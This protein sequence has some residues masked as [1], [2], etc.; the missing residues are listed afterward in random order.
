MEFFV[1]LTRR[2]AIVCA[3]PLVLALTACG[4]AGEASPSP[5]ADGSAETSGDA[6]AAY[7]VT[8][9]NCG[10]EVTVTE[11]PMRIVTIKSTST[12][13]VLA[14]GL[15]DRLVGT[16]FS[17]GP[18]PEDLAGAGA[19][20]PVLAERAPSEEVVLETEPDLVFAGWESNFS[21][22]G[23]GERT[24]LQELGIATYVSPAAC[25]G[26][27]YQP[28]P[29]TFDHIFGSIEE[30]GA[31]LGAPDA[32]T[33]LIE[34]Q[35]AELAEVDA[36]DAGLSALWYSS[37]SDTP[38]VGAGIGAPQLLMETVGLENIMADTAETWAS[39]SWEAVAEQNPDV[40]VLVDSAWNTAEH[41][42]E[43]LE[44]TPT[45]SVLP[46]VQEGRYLIV[47]FPASE[48]G[49]RSVPAATDLAAQLTELEASVP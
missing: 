26:E 38:F 33:E 10:T 28:D 4:S 24:D 9:D 22:D 1:L 34:A 49:V 18:F 15:G 36:S 47:P 25:Q 32:A 48:A 44:S 23:A 8:V 35:Q 21:A 27:G 40:I 14:L 17:D 7:P 30:A 13:M 45:T 2:A 31:L 6:A 42:I 29:L 5:G 19:E 20:A 16:A 46:A 39:V 37:G 41:K 12:E 3:V 43:V 11:A